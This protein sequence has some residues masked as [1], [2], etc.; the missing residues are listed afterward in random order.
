MLV[1]LFG[2][3]SILLCTEAFASVHML[4]ERDK[5]LH[6]SVSSA[7]G[8]TATWVLDDPYESALLCTSVGV[9]KETMDHFDYGRF[10]LADMAFNVAGCGAGILMGELLPPGAVFGYDKDMGWGF[11]FSRH[12]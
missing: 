6:F 3:L 1:R 7:I 5:Q 12:F 4:S 9:A 2:L 10:D 11:S 8:Y